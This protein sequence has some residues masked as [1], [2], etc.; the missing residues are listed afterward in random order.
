MLTIDGRAGG[1]QVLRSALTLSVLRDRPVT[2]EHVRGHRDTPGLRPQHL[3]GIRALAQLT[4]A[5]VAG[6]EVGSREVSFEPRR[7]PRGEIDVDIGTAGSITLLFETVVALGPVLS[8]PISITATGGTDVKWSPTM[9]YLHFVKRQALA[10][11]GLEFDLEVERRGYYPVGGGRATITVYPGDPTELALTAVP[12][13]EGVSVY[14]N[15][16]ASLEDAAVASRQVAGAKEV[17]AEAG[18]PIRETETSYHEG[19]STGTSVTVVGHVEGGYAGGDALGEP[20][21]PAE[22]VG[23]DAAEFIRDWMT[24]DA[25]VDHHLADQLLLPLALAGGKLSVPAVTNHVET[26][27]EVINAFELE[28]TLDESADRPPVLV[29]DPS[30]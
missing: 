21:R 26:N 16:S 10:D 13:I 27:I 18:I 29:S 12:S 25:A 4:D 3:A 2:I 17:L 24:T 9:D 15:A 14:S 11:H 28:M 5:E 23:V 6:D 19:P 7:S 30:R 20:G 1:G 22:E 8:S